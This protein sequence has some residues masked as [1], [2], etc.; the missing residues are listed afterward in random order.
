MV[1]MRIKHLA[2]SAEINLETNL[3]ISIVKL[4]IATANIGNKTTQMMWQ[5]IKCMAQKGIV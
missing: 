1:W 4:A 5:L 2:Q 3:L